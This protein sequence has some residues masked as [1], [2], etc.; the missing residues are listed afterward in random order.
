MSAHADDGATLQLWGNVTLTWIK[1]HQ[2][3]VGLDIEP[4]AVYRSRL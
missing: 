1:N 3:T 4:K 2:L